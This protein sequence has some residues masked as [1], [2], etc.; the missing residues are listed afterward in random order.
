MDD[1]IYYRDGLSVPLAERLLRVARARMYALFTREMTPDSN[2]TI[3]D[4]GVSDEENEASNFL[5]KLHPHTRMITCAGLGD[6]RQVRANFPG[7][8]F[9]QVTEGGRLPF[10]DKNF[11]IVYSNAVLEHVG[12][13]EERRRFA[14]E[15]E[16]VGRRAF[17]AVPNRWFPIEHHT[18]LPLLHYIPPLFRAV[19]R[20]TSMAIWADPKTVDF[21]SAGELR[22]AWPRPGA[23]VVQT[24][25][26]LGPFSSN[27][28][29]IW[30]PD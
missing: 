22:R 24:G 11:D 4:V 23:R 13:A 29:L 1:S 26:P 30:R 21:I 6:G 15:L 7:I 9:V 5:E 25:L 8:N 19:V 2:T 12:G 27:L 28:A 14:A 16:R 3:L 10:P 18:A 20:R 17:I